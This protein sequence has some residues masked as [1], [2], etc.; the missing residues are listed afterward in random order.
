VNNSFFLFSF[1]VHEILP[2][3]FC[4]SSSSLS[5]SPFQSS[6]TVTRENS[7][8]SLAIH[9]PSAQLD[10]SKIKTPTQ[11]PRA[12]HVR[13]DTTATLTVPLPALISVASNPLTARTTSTIMSL[14]LI[15]S[16]VLAARPVSV[17]L[18][19][20]KSKQN[21]VGSSAP[22]ILRNLHSVPFLVPVSE[23]RIQHSPVN[24]WMPKELILLSVPTARKD[25]TKSTGTPTPPDC[26]DSAHLATAWMV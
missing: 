11:V 1:L 14:S 2:E 8:Q 17:P 25:V 20:H 21:L 26:V 24:S 23:D 13:L 5:R 6:P 16:A 19:L 7:I 4:F 18:I 3:P 10:S 9:V 12:K 15:A 22:T